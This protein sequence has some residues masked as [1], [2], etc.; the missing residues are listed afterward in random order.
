MLQKSVSS[1]PSIQ[2]QTLTHS[3]P[4]QSNTKTFNMTRTRFSKHNHVRVKTQQN[5]TFQTSRSLRPSHNQGRGT[6]HP[7]TP[8][9][10]TLLDPFES[11]Q[12]ACRLRSNQ[13]R[14]PPT[15]APTR[16]RTT[17]PS[18]PYIPEYTGIINDNIALMCESLYKSEPKLLPTPWKVNN[19][20][21]DFIENDGD[22]GYSREE[23]EEV[24]EKWLDEVEEVDFVERK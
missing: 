10:P 18:T 22:F 13:P 17:V 2:P 9:T 1:F 20:L 15:P 6:S 23:K 11:D 24:I 19:L 5:L 21:R 16:A 7:S 3:N 12:T 4:I 14:T 8:R